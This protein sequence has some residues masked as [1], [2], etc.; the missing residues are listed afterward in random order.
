MAVL[1]GNVAFSILLFSTKKGYSSFL[2]K[3]LVFSEN[4]FQSNDIENVQNFHWLSR[5]NMPISQTEGCFEN[6]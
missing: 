3:F 4:L 5:K 2:K 1:Y 6:P